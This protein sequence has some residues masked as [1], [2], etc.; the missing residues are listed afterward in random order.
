MASGLSPAP[1]SR[2]GGAREAGVQEAVLLNAEG[3]VA[4]GTTSNVFMV[5]DGRL[6]TPIPQGIQAWK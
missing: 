2:E 1:R 4:E 3:Y 6:R 5:S